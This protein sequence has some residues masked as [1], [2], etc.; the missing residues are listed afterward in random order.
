M[1]QK[2]QKK[3]KIKINGKKTG[4]KKAIHNNIS[5]KEKKKRQKDGG[6]T[7]GRGRD[8]KIK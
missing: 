4:K 3:Q 5:T 6:P 8:Q 2:T 7:P 1:T